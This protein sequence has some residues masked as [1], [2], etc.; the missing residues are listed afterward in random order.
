[1]CRN[2]LNQNSF[3]QLL[4]IQYSLIIAKD[5]NFCQPTIKLTN[6]HAKQW[7]IRR[8]VAKNNCD[9]MPQLKMLFRNRK[10]Q[11][12][13][14]W[15]FQLSRLFQVPSGRLLF[16]QGKFDESIRPGFSTIDRHL[17]TA[18]SR[19]TPVQLKL[20]LKNATKRLIPSDLLSLYISLYESAPP[21]RER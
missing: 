3:P 1:M 13:H 9:D 11:S 15:E 4:F 18:T 17:N 19:A 10:M 14:E 12:L 2:E 7:R 16:I 8:L 20:P 6:S 21:T 5:T